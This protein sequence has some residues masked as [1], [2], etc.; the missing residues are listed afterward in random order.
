MTK[1]PDSITCPKC[2]KTSYHPKD[3]SE[4]YCGNC[5]EYHDQMEVKK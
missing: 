2:G 1:K 3:I 4:R 5:H